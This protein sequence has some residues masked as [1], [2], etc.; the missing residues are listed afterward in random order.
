ML[1]TVVYDMRI[2]LF[3]LLIV[4]MGFGEAF[5]RLSENSENAHFIQNYA[6]SIVYSFR[7]SIGDTDTDSFDE[8]L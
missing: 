7:L 3:I 6:Y 4:Y 5:L 8:T 2:F 1:S